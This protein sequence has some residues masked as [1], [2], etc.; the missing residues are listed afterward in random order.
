M[1]GFLSKIKQ[2]IKKLNNREL[3]TSMFHF[4]LKLVLPELDQYLTIYELTCN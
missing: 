2:E 4:L 1:K 3:K